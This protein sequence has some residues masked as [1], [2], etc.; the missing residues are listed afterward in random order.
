MQIQ[1]F[2]ETV[3]ASIAVGLAVG[4]FVV[5]DDIESS[6]A[7]SLDDAGAAPAIV[8]DAVKVDERSPD[9]AG[10]VTSPALKIQS[11]A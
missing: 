4:P 8:T 3:C 5:H 7:K 9:L 2:E 10:W 6:G 11:F 1:L